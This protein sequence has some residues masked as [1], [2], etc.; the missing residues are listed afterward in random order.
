MS[1]L[2]KGLGGFLLCDWLP[3]LD[4]FVCDTLP[5]GAEPGPCFHPI[6]SKLGCCPGGL[7]TRTELTVASSADPYSMGHSSL[8]RDLVECWRPP[9]VN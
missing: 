3:L 2:G 1:F 4:S 7:E 8:H 9:G 6:G 5:A